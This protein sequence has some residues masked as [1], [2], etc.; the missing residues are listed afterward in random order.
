MA[1]SVCVV[2]NSNSPN[3]SG[4]LLIAD[5]TVEL[6]GVTAVHQR[7]CHSI[8]TNAITGVRKTRRADMVRA[9]RCDCTSADVICTVS[10]DC[11]RADVICA[12]CQT[13]PAPT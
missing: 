8:R 12:I 7:G 2:M 11:A 13:A 3:E 10:C 5:R 6:V 4:A 1:V 9:V